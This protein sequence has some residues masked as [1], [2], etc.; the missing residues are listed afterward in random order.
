MGNSASNLPPL[1]PASSCLTEKFMGPWFVIA[2]KPTVFEKHN[3]N[4]VET[5][6][7][8][9][10][11]NPKA[12]YDIDIDFQFNKRENGPASPLS[13][14]GQK[15]Y[16][17]GPD[18][19]N[20]GLWKISPLWPLKLDYFLLEVEYDDYCIVGSDRNRN[21]A[22][23]MSRT[24]QMKDRTYE[25]CIQLLKEKHQYDL[26]GLR[27][28]PQIWTKEERSKRG[29]DKVIPDRMLQK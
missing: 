3:S 21:Y 4:A 26:E 6:T 22:W 12:K 2:V 1:V 10:K 23:I 5:Y 7:W 18:K 8:V 20:S 9:S 27:K 29:L 15:G 28:V 14:M 11:D 17:Q 13:S 25:K 19:S 24:P 16:I